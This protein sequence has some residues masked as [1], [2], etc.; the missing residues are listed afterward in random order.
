MDNPGRN[1]GEGKGVIFA[2]AA[3]AAIFSICSIFVLA[4]KDS[5]ELRK[6]V[7]EIGSAR[8]CT[9]QRQLD[10][11]LSATSALAA[12]IHQCGAIDNFD[13]LGADMME[14]YGGISSLQLAP[15]TVVRQIYP[16]QISAGDA[17]A[18]DQVS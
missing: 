16:F 13:E 12:S 17:S 5:S 1:S 8:S 2:A 15:D 18:L 10:R 11:S 14:R 6:K 7:A 4:Q 9:L 3:F